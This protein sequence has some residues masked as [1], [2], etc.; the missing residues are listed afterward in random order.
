ML[1]FE[2]VI[3]NFVSLVVLDSHFDAPTKNK[4]QVDSSLHFHE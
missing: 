2:N 1:D 4:Q 3:S